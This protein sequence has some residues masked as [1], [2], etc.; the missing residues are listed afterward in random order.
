MLLLTGTHLPVQHI[1]EIST[2]DAAA[3]QVL[4]NLENRLAR[5][6][7]MIINFIDPDAI[8]IG[9]GLSNLSRLY[10][11]IPLQW[12]K[13]VFSDTVKTVLLA[14]KYGDSSGIRGAAWL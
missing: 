6:F 7:A 13:Y 9:G 12:G 3:Q 11:A 8:V 4:L 14:P 2:T 5:A 1:A 10:S